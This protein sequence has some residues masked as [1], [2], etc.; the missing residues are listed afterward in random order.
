MFALR[1]A[2]TDD[3][4]IV[5]TLLQRLRVRFRPRART[6]GQHRADVCVVGRRHRRLLERTR[7]G[8][9]RLSG[10]AARSAAAGLGCVG[11]QRRP[12]DL[13][14]RRRAERPR[15]AGRRGRRA[16][17]LGTL[18]STASTL[19]KQ[20]I[21]R[22]RIDCHWVD[23]QMFTAIK[24]R[25][26]RALQGWQQRLQD[27]YGYHSTRLIEREELRATAGDASATSA[28]CTT[29][30]A[31]ICIRCAT[32]SAWR[33]PPRRPALRSTRAVA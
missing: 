19:L 18:T 32:P 13:R 9:A 22:H 11:A 28:R 7:A 23:G 17:H 30:T 16:P 15:A 25:Q 26:W 12:G 8:R 14:R 31:G 4:I 33:E 2:P 1:S 21:A 20:R 3:L 24:P 5:A 10:G 6:A 27:R 29:P